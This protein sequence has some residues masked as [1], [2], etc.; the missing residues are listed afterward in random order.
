MSELNRS[1]WEV[2]Y[3]RGPHAPDH[4]EIHWRLWAAACWIVRDRLVAFAASNY[5]IGSGNGSLTGFRVQDGTLHEITSVSGLPANV[6]GI[7]AVDRCH[8]GLDIV[9]SARCGL[10]QSW[11]LIGHDSDRKRR[12]TEYRP[13][14]DVTYLAA[15][16]QQSRQIEGHAVDQLH[17]TDEAC[18][19][20]R[21]D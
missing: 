9:S 10:P 6:Q 21:L 15:A 7:A 8:A 11:P 17:T 4:H 14:T 18:V 16:I 3:D 12:T 20:P 1:Q 2:E 13:T 19:Y 5:M